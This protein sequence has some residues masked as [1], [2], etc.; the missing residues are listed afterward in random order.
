MTAQMLVEKMARA[1]RRQRADAE[2]EAAEAHNERA[3]ADESQ[4]G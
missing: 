1:V 4:G 2:K 3:A